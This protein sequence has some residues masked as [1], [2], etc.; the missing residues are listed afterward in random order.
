MA[1]VPGG[2]KDGP[3]AEEWM[4]LAKCIQEDMMVA[5]QETVQSAAAACAQICIQRLQ[6][7]H[8]EIGCVVQESEAQRGGGASSLHMYVEHVHQCNASAFQKG[9]SNNEFGH[10]R[11]SLCEDDVDIEQCH[12]EDNLRQGTNTSIE[13]LYLT[14][15]WETLHNSS[16]IDVVA[17]T[18]PPL[19]KRCP[20][21]H[22]E[23]G[24]FR[25]AI[26]R[27]YWSP[28]TYKSLFLQLQALSQKHANLKIAT[29][30]SKGEIFAKGDSSSIESAKP[31][32]IRI[33][34]EHF[35]LV[36]IPESLRVSV[37]GQVALG[38][39]GPLL[40][41]RTLCATAEEPLAAQHAWASDFH[42]SCEG[43]DGSMPS[44]ITAALAL[45]SP[46]RNVSR[47]ATTPT[48]PRGRAMPKCR[49]SLSGAWRPA[50]SG[51]PT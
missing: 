30:I 34:M 41:Q 9:R 50:G 5:L 22:S 21:R 49:R 48:S 6:V 4:Q 26:D 40:E 1:P 47:R 31:E 36:A 8:K 33:V 11:Y 27:R 43:D 35:P 46:R 12:D 42:L 39:G 37:A 18:P 45:A 44:G 23:V 28:A 2:C 32:L 16:S 13:D 25:I 29:F 51:N 17:L 10:K 38:G 20:R 3:Q 7:L 24:D 14:A 15:N 19:L